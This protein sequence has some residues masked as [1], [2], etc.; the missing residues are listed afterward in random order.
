MNANP[1]NET[2]TDI[3]AVEP[4][5]EDMASEFAE[6]AGTTEVATPET[7]AAESTETPAEP[8]EP[9][10]EENSDQTQTKTEDENPEPGTV[11]EPGTEE[12]QQTDGLPEEPSKQ[13]QAFAQL[14]VEN[15]AQKDALELAAKLSG[16]SV[17]EFVA[18]LKE[19]QIKAD[20]LKAGT[21]PEVFKR[22]Q[23]LE[24]QNNAME[25]ERTKLAFQG[26]VQ[27][28]QAQ[29]SLSND[30]V[31]VFINTMLDKGIVPHETDIDFNILYRGLNF[32]KLV[33]NARQDWIAK[34]AR[35][36]DGS[37]T[38]GSTQ[39]RTE[40]NESSEVKTQEDFE[41]LFNQHATSLK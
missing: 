38:P 34:S 15:K 3:P 29:N 10:T 21:T 11:E 1:S 40:V 31:N 36:R 12:S 22:I 41:K 19:E 24:N 14:R 35:N 28:F 30:D 8:D 4:Q 13:N 27:T 25:L 33:E 2:T 37:S 9:G 5:F 39:S 16:K 20:A 23:D 17:E 26:R 7:D 18:S 6:M 32:D